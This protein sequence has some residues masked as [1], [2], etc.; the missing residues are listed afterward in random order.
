MS[1]TLLF[2]NKQCASCRRLLTADISTFG[3]SRQSPDGLFSYCKECK[4]QRAIRLKESKYGPSKR[5][6]REKMSILELDIQNRLVLIK[7]M[8]SLPFKGIMY[9]IPNKSYSDFHIQVVY[10]GSV[11]FSWKDKSWTITVPSK[12]D[13]IPMMVKLLKEN[14]F[15]LEESLSTLQ[16][17]IHEFFK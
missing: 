6:H 9:D 2:P 7:A 11:T 5:P 3:G 8:A 15:R 14:N 13:A 12:H 1:P 17:A 16:L 4:A 10:G